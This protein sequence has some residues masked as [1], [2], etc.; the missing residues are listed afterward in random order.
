MCC[1]WCVVV[2]VG[3][4]AGTAILC[5]DCQQWQMHAGLNMLGT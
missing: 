3:V 5:L 4:I 2:L 1:L